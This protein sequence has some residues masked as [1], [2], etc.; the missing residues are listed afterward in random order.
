M[1]KQIK[2]E[3]LKLTPEEMKQLAEGA[4]KFL[5]TSEEEPEAPP[6]E[7]LVEPRGR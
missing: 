4:R 7:D 3:D 2:F 6:V 1:P 5:P